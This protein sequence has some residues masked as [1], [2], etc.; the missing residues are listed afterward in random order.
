[1]RRLLLALPFATAAGCA[2][3]LADYPSLAP[4]AV[5]STS[6]LAPLPDTSTAGAP[7]T[8]TQRA[9]MDALERRATGGQRAFAAAMTVAERLARSAG[10]RDSEG[11]LVAQQALSRA[12]SA[13]VPSVEAL[14][15]LDSR[16]AALRELAARE[17]GTAGLSDTIA[18]RARVAATVSA[19]VDRLN[20]VRRSLR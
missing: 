15:D 16:V 9:E 19:Q 3:S 4:R 20:A 18:S 14:A 2:P 6:P 11:W 13:R 10:R 1:M 17:P 5:E 12:E 8:T 7:A